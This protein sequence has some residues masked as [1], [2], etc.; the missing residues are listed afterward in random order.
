MLPCFDFCTKLLP[1]KYNYESLYL[2]YIS[3]MTNASGLG[4]I[5]WCVS[6]FICISSV[7]AKFYLELSSWKLFSLK[8]NYVVQYIEPSHSLIRPKTTSVDV[9]CKLRHSTGL[10]YFCRAWIL[11][12]TYRRKEQESVVSCLFHTKS[13][14][15]PHKKLTSTYI[16]H[17]TLLQPYYTST[18]IL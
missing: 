13:C 5:P 1:T 14:R 7:S 2:Y 4:I 17:A 11:W 3:A 16:L 10:G 6:I 8:P 15:K 12:N 9:I 18:S